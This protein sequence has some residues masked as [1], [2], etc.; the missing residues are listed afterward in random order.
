MHKNKQ[1]GKNH[2]CII[3]QEGE[4]TGNSTDTRVTLTSHHLNAFNQTIPDPQL[5]L[6]L[7]LSPSILFCN[8]KSCGDTTALNP[9]ECEWG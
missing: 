4:E 1:A 5:A 3:E 6:F 8:T 9:L 2:G 7:P